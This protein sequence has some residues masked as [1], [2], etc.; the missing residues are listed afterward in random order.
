[1]K[2]RSLAKAIIPLLTISSLVGCS[3]GSNNTLAINDEQQI[4]AVL[5]QYEQAM[6]TRNAERLADLLIYPIET[7]EGTFATKERAVALY[8]LGFRMID[9]DTFAFSNHEIV[10]NDKGAIARMTQRFKR[11]V[12]GGIVLDEENEVVYT[13]RKLGGQWK[14]SGS[15]WV[16]AP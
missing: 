11:T 10:F 16:M 8:S 13:L 14:I 7:L 2:L 4:Y 5:H 3:S 9:T 6:T 12:L 1:M 15:K